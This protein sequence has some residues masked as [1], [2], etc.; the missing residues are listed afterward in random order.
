MIRKVPLGKSAALS[1]LA[2][3]ANDTDSN[4]PKQADLIPMAIL[5]PMVERSS[6]ALSPYCLKLIARTDRKPPANVDGRFAISE[7]DVE[8]SRARLFK[9]QPVTAQAP[10]LRLGDIIRPSMHKKN[11]L[12]RDRSH[13]RPTWHQAG[14][15]T[16]RCKPNRSDNAHLNALQAR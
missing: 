13:R 3:R 4:A 7:G 12:L 15:V 2:L 10:R 9:S 5:A 11:L 6:D 1:A 8:I 16:R 14:W